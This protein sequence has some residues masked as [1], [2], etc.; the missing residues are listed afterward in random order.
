M[1][2]ASSASSQIKE[3]ELAVS[4]WTD[5]VDRDA[6]VALASELIA[7]PS[8]SGEEREIMEFVTGW[9]AGR[10][11]R[12]QAF[13]KDPNRP[14]IVIS[15]GDPA[16]GPTIAM[17]GHLDT[18]PVSDPD[19]WESDPFAPT[20]SPDGTML[21]GR[22][23]VDMKSAVAV[24]MTVVDGLQGADLQGCLQAHVVS[25]EETSGLYGTVHL[26][27]EI[28]AGRLN[29][30]TYCLIGEKS[31]L[32]VRN[33]ERGI[34]NF[35]VT[36]HGRASH[37]AAARATGI[38]AIAKA[39]KGVLA[40]EKEID[41]FHPAIGKPVISVNTIHAGV[42][43]NVVPG[44]CTITVDRRLIPGETRDTAMAEVQ[45]AFAA[46]AAEDPDFRFTIVED[47]DNNYIP[48]NI[49]EE[50]SPLVQTVQ[51]S[52]RDVTGEAPEYFVAWAG[53]T[54]GRFYRQAGID[55]VGFGP[56]GRNAHGANEAVVID[57]LVTQAKVYTETAIRLLGT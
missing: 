1:S 42:A 48:A 52:V 32:K 56:G 55:T 53:A 44:E 11:L 31:D 12:H 22:G 27:G 54:D 29:R 46:I 6:I 47:P 43:H 24:M 41:R 28:A 37:T 9:C 26:L 25:D 33:A 21:I 57:D 20:V 17:N 13:A 39:A 18:V 34:F 14:N 30:P 36:F 38:N 49:T 7:I 4:S 50:T 5:R 40:L 19:A 2:N 51:E 16:A 8:S 10:G 23:A 45:E 15:I 35:A 3:P